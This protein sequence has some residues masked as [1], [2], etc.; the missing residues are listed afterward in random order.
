MGGSA[1]SYLMLLKAVMATVD[2]NTNRA[3]NQAPGYIF[4]ADRIGTERPVI[5]H[6]ALVAN[7]GCGATDCESVG[8]SDCH[9]PDW[10]WHVNCKL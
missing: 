10:H 3:E 9:G 7:A 4:L 8:Y 6:V 2:E 1:G 5:G